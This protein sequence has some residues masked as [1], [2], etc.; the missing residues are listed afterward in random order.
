[1]GDRYISLEEGNGLNR[2]GW[3]EEGKNR[4]IKCGRV[5]RLVTQE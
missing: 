4:R 5:R 2:Y 3:N 1:M